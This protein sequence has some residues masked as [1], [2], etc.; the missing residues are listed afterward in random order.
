VA[1]DGTY[2][3]W[4]RDSWRIRPAK[5]RIS[6]GDPLTPHSA[7]PDGVS[8]EVAYEVVTDELKKRIQRMLDEMRRK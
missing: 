3:V 2:R 5:V 6:F 1:I 8:R 7:I 4:P